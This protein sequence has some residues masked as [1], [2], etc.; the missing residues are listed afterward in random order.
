MRIAKGDNLPKGFGYKS[1]LDRV[2]LLSTY[3]PTEWSIL[4][5][6]PGLP[7]TSLTHLVLRP[8]PSKYATH[9]TTGIKCESR[10]VRA[11]G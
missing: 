8:S 1:T 6:G 7:L 11:I 10:S 4:T 2:E 5:R 9:Q 3:W